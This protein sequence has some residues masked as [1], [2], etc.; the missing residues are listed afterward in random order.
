MWKHAPISCLSHK[1]RRLP[2]ANPS[3]KAPWRSVSVQQLLWASADPQHSR[4]AKWIMHAQLSLLIKHLHYIYIQSVGLG[5]VLESWSGFER[6]NIPSG[7]DTET[8]LAT[9]N[10]LL[11]KWRNLCICT[12]NTCANGF[13][14]CVHCFFHEYKVRNISCLHWKVY[15]RRELFVH[16]SLSTSVNHSACICALWDCSDPM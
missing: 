2:R 10:S 15:L 11:K 14:L 8:W 7:R 9:D 12:R 4:A 5:K 3:L 1:N 6:E 16:K 13:N